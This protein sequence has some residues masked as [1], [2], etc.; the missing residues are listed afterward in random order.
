MIDRRLG[1]IAD[2]Y[3]GATDLSSMLRRSGCRVIQCFEVP[4]EREL[5][6]L[7]EADAVV[8]AL[9]SRSIAAEKAI[10]LSLRALQTL[11]TWGAERFFF[12][13]C[14]TFD[15]TPAGNIGPVADALADALGVD[16]LYFCPAFP[17]NGRTVHC[18]HLFV[19]GTPLNE[20][21]MRFHPLNPMTDSS[22]V[23]VL[24]AQTPQSV[25][26]CSPYAEAASLTSSRIIV[27]AVRNEDLRAAA[28]MAADH[29]LLTGGSAVASYWVE[30][31]GIRQS[32]TWPEMAFSTVESSPFVILAGSC[33]DATRS[34]VRAFEKEHPVFHL[35][36]DGSKSPEAIADQA[37]RWCANNLSKPSE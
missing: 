5:D 32:E 4:D 20:S 10:E 14:S 8:V 9:K 22:L 17:E 19:C 28:E 36:V 21:G 25:D 33:S 13:Y 16:L 24:Q 30:A 15:S 34:Q 37:L 6:G 27:D 3:T 31:A 11:K 29:V 1:C 26:W 12:K 7:Q 35:Q 2:D 23:R 18:G